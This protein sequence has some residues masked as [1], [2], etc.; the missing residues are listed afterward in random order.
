[1]DK[2]VL[3][4]GVSS[5]VG[6][7]ALALWKWLSSRVD[8]DVSKAVV[9]EVTALA[10]LD[11][12]IHE[13]SQKYLPE[14]VELLKELIRMPVDSLE[15]DPSSGLSGH[16][17]ARVEFLQKKIIEIGAVS[18]QNDISVDE[19][20]QLTWRVIDRDDTTPLKERKT[21]YLVSRCDTK[22]AN[23]AEWHSTLGSGIDAYTG[24]SD[25]FHV[26]EEEMESQ[27]G[28]VP[29]KD[30]WDSL[31]FGRGA[32][33]QLA[34]LVAQIYATKIMVETLEM[35]CLKGVVVIAVATVCGME[36]GGCS[37]THAMSKELDIWQI[38]DCVVLC[39][40]TGDIVEGPFGICIGEPGR[41]DIDVEVSG[42]SDGLNAFEYGSLIIS[43]AANEAKKI[44]KASFMG[45]G[46]RHVVWTRN[47]P[48]KDPAMSSKFTFRFARKTTTGEDRVQMLKEVHMLKSIDRARKSGMTVNITVPRFVEKTW[49]DVGAISTD[50]NYPMW[51]T[52]PNNPVITAAFEAYSRVVTPHVK[53]RPSVSKTEDIPLRPRLTRFLN[54]TEG[55][56]FVIPK[57]DVEYDRSKKRWIKHDRNVYPP[58]F[59]FGAGY[60]QHSGKL[61]EYVPQDQ[62]WVP[63]S[64]LARFPQML[65][66]WSV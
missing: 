44:P 17:R 27:L 36:H 65:V 37:I 61:G 11:H 18:T 62:L 53:G 33:D 66:K 47:E 7:T 48:A 25:T 14:A 42:K 60:Q 30:K 46:T 39:Q 1:M 10:D 63:I 58:M 13:L 6:V 41:C 40:P 50:M 45:P 35:G 57:E 24:V 15:E 29:T 26:N 5:A 55:V 12:R 52:N 21:I 22:K 9:P 49:K 20:G 31:V 32:A 3:I 19:F 8:V 4:G 51:V 2:R 28:F 64:M 38:P 43:E 54:S 16:E 59:G 23:N 34:G 56:G